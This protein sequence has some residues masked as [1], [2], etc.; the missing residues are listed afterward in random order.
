MISEDQALTLIRQFVKDSQDEPHMLDGIKIAFQ[1]K[2]DKAKALATLEKHFD[3]F[4][5]FQDRSCL[6]LLA[7]VLSDKDTEILRRFYN[8]RLA[9]EDDPIC[10]KLIKKYL[11]H[12][13]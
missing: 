12:L 10:H 6:Y 1:L 2:Q 5:G 7:R 8:A 3:A 13:K 9:V 11:E 4:T